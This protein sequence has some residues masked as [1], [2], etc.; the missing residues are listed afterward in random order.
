MNG[1]QRA[2]CV[3]AATLGVVLEAGAEQ[4]SRP[5]A[6]AAAPPEP[7]AWSRPE[8][9]SPTTTGAPQPY[10]PRPVATPL[11]VRPSRTDGHR[12]VYLRAGFGTGWFRMKTNARA[13]G[14]PSRRTFR[15]GTFVSELAVGGSLSPQVALGAGIA[16]ER[17]IGLEGERDDGRSVA[18]GDTRFLLY[19]VGP[20]FDV[21]PFGDFGLHAQATMGPAVLRIQR[22]TGAGTTGD[23]PRGFGLILGVGY[24]VGVHRRFGIGVSGKVGFTWMDQ[25]DSLA[26]VDLRS[27]T[28]SLAVTL[29][30]N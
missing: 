8:A 16:L 23:D 30:V 25:N 21:Y 1:R 7:P 2:V 3:V 29:T 5:S 19:T 17:V 28:P 10:E 13:L 6:P 22:R 9:P 27:I 11:D 4:R 14:E 15:G 12:G 20:Q 24:D 18:I 26:D